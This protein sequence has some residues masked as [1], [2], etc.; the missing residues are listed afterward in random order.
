MSSKKENLLK[1]WEA[2]ESGKKDKV[3]MKD[4]NNYGPS[5]RLKTDR[6]RGLVRVTPP[7][8]KIQTSSPLPTKPPED[9]KTTYET[10]NYDNDLPLLP[11]QDILT[12]PTKDRVRRERRQKSNQRCK[13]TQNVSRPDHIHSLNQT[14]PAAESEF[15]VH[16]G[17]RYA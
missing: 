12:Q 3:A 7:I 16:N 15:D 10:F 2:M 17:R 5:P 1:F 4:Q 11:R 13:N 9:S 8:V 14:P 6:G